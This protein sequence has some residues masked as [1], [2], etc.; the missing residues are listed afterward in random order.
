MQIRTLA[1]ARS[2][3]Q[4][5][6]TLFLLVLILAACEALPELPFLPGS[7]EP[8]AT[9]AVETETPPVVRTRVA[10]SPTPEETENQAV[11]VHLKVW[12]P[13][14]FDPNAGTPAGELLKTR[15]EEFQSAYPYVS[16]EVR[17]KAVLGTGGSAG[18]I[19]DR[20]CSCTA[21]DTRF[22]C[23]PQAL[24]ESAVLQGLIYPFDGLTTA[25]DDHEWYE[26]ARQLGQLQNSVYGLP[27]AGDALTMAYRP[28][29]IET[30]PRDWEATTAISGTLA[31]PA[32]DPQALFTL[33]QYQAAG[34][35]VQNEQGQPILEEE[36]LVEVLNFFQTAEMTGVM[37][38]WLTQFE[39]FDQ[40]WE[41]FSG[42]Q[43]SM[44]VSWF[45]SYQNH[46][47]SLPTHPEMAVLP[48]PDGRDYT[49]G[50]GWVWAIASSKLDRHELSA[51]LAEY[52]LEDTF[53][54]QWTFETGYLPPHSG[55][56]D[57]WRD[58]QLRTLMHQIQSSA[59]LLPSTEVIA[60][61]GPLLKQAAVDV[62]KEQSDPFSA[63][64]T[65]IE[66]LENR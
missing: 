31:F 61:L 16:V 43:S 10:T 45:S 66:S 14:Q 20:Q 33:L 64:R 8:P 35:A 53:L 22:N 3:L 36:S 50:T 15:L 48:T 2:L 37:P 58:V 49:L 65:A 21:G 39:N 38:F 25:M 24:M 62:L 47:E 6:V 13:P 32:A 55:A 11:G 19:D 57:N 42:R 17:L 5:L 41:S 23:L 60:Q 54:G 52:L 1:L 12:L 28:V 46:Y 44:A 56:L 7:E 29:L 63:A 59:H 9:D 26:Y 4:R 30:P 27:F 18:F 51:R 40:V 34:G